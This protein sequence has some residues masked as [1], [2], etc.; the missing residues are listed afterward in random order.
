LI[1]Q[2]LEKVEIRNKITVDFVKTWVGRKIYA[3]C[4]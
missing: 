4:S 2:L 1:N 3:A